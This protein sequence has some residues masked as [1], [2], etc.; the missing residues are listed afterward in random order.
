MTGAVASSAPLSI[1]VVGAGGVGGYF[2]GRLAR[3]GEPVTFLARGAHLD[4]L[5]AR[6]LTVRSAVEGEWTVPVDAVAAL[7]GRGPADVVLL[8]VKGFDT[9]AALEAVRP[10]VGPATA[11]VSLQ[12]GVE[13]VERIAAAFGPGHAVGGAAY[14]FAALEAPGVVVHRFAGRLV[15]G[16][17]DGQPSARCQR[18]LAALARAGVPTELSRDIRRVL[19]EKYAF[20]GAQ[21]GVTALT[22]C[23]TGVIRA[24][25]ET[26]R[27]YRALVEEFVA[28]G[29]AAGVALPDDTVDRVM[30]AAAALAP[31][32]TSSL[33]HDLAHGRRL[34]LETL[35]GYAVR[36][37]E[38][39]GVPLPTV[40]AVYAALKPHAAGA[41]R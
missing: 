7:D 19:W 8:C 41:P 15:V 38:R 20:I 23:P 29:R 4:A 3:A 21:A 11:V 37:G 16:E 39:L 18:L 33:A 40:A 35:H 24:I 27:L 31:D 6:G 26:W 14:V 34:E 9:D 36:L 5:R 13:A 32:T 2:G 12:N 30:A 22:R 1:V 25:P 28:L 17:L 10:V